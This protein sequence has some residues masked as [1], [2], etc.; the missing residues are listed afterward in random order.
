M[1]VALPVDWFD[2]A[3]HP[4]IATANLGTDPS[5]TSL[6]PPEQLMLW[7][8]RHM[9]VCWPSCGSVRTALHQVYGD[10]ALGVEHLLRCLLTALGAY[11]ARKLQVGDPTCSILLADEGSILFAL[12]SARHDPDAARDALVDLCAEPRAARLLPLAASLAQVADC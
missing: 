4:E 8:M 1:N 2:A 9:L 5:W 10:E 12:R 6:P 11:S 7:S 3:E